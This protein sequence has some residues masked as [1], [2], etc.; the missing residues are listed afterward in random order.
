MNKI[1]I[2]IKKI[3]RGNLLDYVSNIQNKQ[4]KNKV[5]IGEKRQQSVYINGNREINLN[6]DKDGINS[7]N[8]KATIINNNS[9]YSEHCVRYYRMEGGRDIN[10]DDADNSIVCKNQYDAI[11]SSP[12]TQRSNSLLYQ[13]TVFERE[14]IDSRSKMINNVNINCFNSSNNNNTSINDSNSLKSLLSPIS[15]LP[16]SINFSTSIDSEGFHSGS[17]DDT[18]AEILLED[19]IPTTG[20][21]PRPMPRTSRNNSLAE[22]SSSSAGSGNGSGSCSGAITTSNVLQSSVDAMNTPKPKPRTSLPVSYK[23]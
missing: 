21:T 5:M 1:E 3:H 18:N 20:Q 13:S 4:I 12:L 19:G 6:S 16:S 23:V 10:N 14:E 7:S 2:E 22:Y 11:S 9:P 17:V 15:T 8:K